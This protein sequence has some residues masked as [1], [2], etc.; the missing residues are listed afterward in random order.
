MIFKPQRVNKAAT[1]AVYRL[2]AGEE[3]TVCCVA[4]GERWL[5]G[6]VS[7][8]LASSRQLY[9]WSLIG[10]LVSSSRLQLKNQLG[11]KEGLKKRVVVRQFVGICE[12]DLAA[13]QTQFGGV[14]SGGGLTCIREGLRSCGSSPALT[15]PAPRPPATT[16]MNRGVRVDM[17]QD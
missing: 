7:C 12:R 16:N 13:F 14:I 17:G 8:R 4:A 3:L 11:L 2:H 9:Q 6:A 15:A 10:S 1:A 5:V